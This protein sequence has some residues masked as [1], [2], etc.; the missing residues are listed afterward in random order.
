MVKKSLGSDIFST[1]HVDDVIKL[2]WVT[3]LDHQNAVSIRV[4]HPHRA[5]ESRKTCTHSPET[6]QYKQG[7]LWIA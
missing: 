4:R 2:H 7:L 5:R 6:R 3:F 1:S